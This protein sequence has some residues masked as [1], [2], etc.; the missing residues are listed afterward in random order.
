MKKKFLMLFAAFAM[1][2][3]IFPVYSESASAACDDPDFTW[4]ITI[5]RFG[6]SRCFDV[7]SGY[8]SPPDFMAGKRHEFAIRCG[9]A[10]PNKQPTIA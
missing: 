7:P 1:F 3:S 2:L 10:K 8:C 9:G 4:T 6:T 5:E